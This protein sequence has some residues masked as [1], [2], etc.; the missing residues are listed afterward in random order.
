MLKAVSD[1]SDMSQCAESCE[2][3]TNVIS[4]CSNSV[5]K[6][7]YNMSAANSNERVDE[8]A[9]DVAQQFE[10]EGDPSSS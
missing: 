6:T 2:V 10:P 3:V 7:K 5:Y 8:S 1:K 4:E 9:A